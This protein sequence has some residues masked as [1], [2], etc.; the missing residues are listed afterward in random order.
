MV[1]IIIG[2]KTFRSCRL[3]A[4]KEAGEK[5]TRINS[6]SVYYFYYDVGSRLYIA[7]L[8]P[9]IFSAS[10]V[11]VQFADGRQLCRSIAHTHD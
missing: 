5:E 11:E 6:Y 7:P 4:L 2:N 1:L 3:K 10:S 8:F 9:S